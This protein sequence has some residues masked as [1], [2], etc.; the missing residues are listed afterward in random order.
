M[1]CNLLAKCLKLIGRGGG[2]QC[3]QNPD[4]A[5]TIRQRAVDITNDRTFGYAQGLH[6]AQCHVFTDF[7]NQVRQVFRN[8]LAVQRCRSQRFNRRNTNGFFGKLRDEAL[9][10]RVTGYEVCFA[11]Q[12]NNGG[13]R[14]FNANGNKAFCGNATGFLG[15]LGQT[16]LAKPVHRGFHVAVVFRQGF[17]GIHHARA[18]FFP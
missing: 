11:V 10:F 18:C 6:P 9:E 13:F 14:A 2:F 7:R 5:H 3:N 1:H 16:L 17:F 4:L 8:R 15:G 12:F